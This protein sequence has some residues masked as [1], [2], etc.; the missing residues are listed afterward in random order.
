MSS[1]ARSEAAISAAAGSRSMSNFGSTSGL[2]VSPAFPL[3][4]PPAEEP[5]AGGPTP[6]SR[7][8]C[9]WYTAWGS[10]TRP[11]EREVVDLAAHVGA[12]VCARRRRTRRPPPTLFS[13]ASKATVAAVLRRRVR[14]ATSASDTTKVSAAASMPSNRRQSTRKEAR[15]SAHSARDRGFQRG[16][17]GREQ[18]LRLLQ[19]VLVEHGL[20]L[21]VEDAR[22]RQGRVR[23]DAGATGTAASPAAPAA[24]A[25]AGPACPASDTA[26]AS[27][28]S[29]SR[30]RRA[31]ASPWRTARAARSAARSPARAAAA[32]CRAA[33]PSPA[34]RT[35]ARR[36]AVTYS[37][38]RRRS[39]S[40]WLPSLGSM[41][42]GTAGRECRS[43]WLRARADVPVGAGSRRSWARR[44][45]PGAVSVDRKAR[46]RGQL[47]EPGLR[48]RLGLGAVEL[49]YVVR[50][51]AG[52]WPLSLKWPRRNPGK[53]TGR[54]SENCQ[55]TT[56][57]ICAE[58]FLQFLA[59]PLFVTLD[60]A[61]VRG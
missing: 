53:S 2:N 45:R 28:R 47:D 29:A 22:R 55:H 6:G 60:F 20:D 36:Q 19:Q 34:R 56:C 9:V 50:D 26:G 25:A 5:L 15:H 40:R 11:G 35:A 30:R 16:P 37:R 13:S 61:A 10:G 59:G 17:E 12:P 52:T 49:G 38:A 39:A 41:P 58:I 14:S 8:W 21:A 31:R 48:R 18:A 24:A 46:A 43:S 33:S 1:R 23:A 57:G 4:L 44:R 27:A 54:K 32:A 42:T 3:P 51:E 7:T